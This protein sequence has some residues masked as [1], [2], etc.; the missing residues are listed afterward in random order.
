MA[1]QTVIHQKPPAIVRFVKKN[2]SIFDRMRAGGPIRVFRLMA[3]LTSRAHFLHITL[4]ET[5]LLG[6]LP[7]DV[8]H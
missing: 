5:N 1:A 6:N 8:A 7:A 4:R 2:L 3:G